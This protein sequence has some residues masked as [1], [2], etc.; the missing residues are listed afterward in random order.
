MVTR[1]KSPNNNKNAKTAKNRE[2]SKRR[3]TVAAKYLKGWHQ[4][5]IADHCEVSVA[6]ICS[7]LK[8]LHKQWLDR[9][10]QH[11]DRHMARELAKLDHLEAEAWESYNESKQATEHYQRESQKNTARPGKP[12]DTTKSKGSKILKSAGDSRFLLIVENCIDKRCKILGIN[13][14]KR[15][16]V[17]GAD[18]GPIKTENVRLEAVQTLLSAI[19]QANIP[20][21]DDENDKRKSDNNDK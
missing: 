16:E 9:S 15:V 7:D 4:Q 21:T 1:E 18:G 10:Q 8:A 14:A 20:L 17:T 5:K 12:L 19:R 3:A 6:T 2:I 11:Y 13:A